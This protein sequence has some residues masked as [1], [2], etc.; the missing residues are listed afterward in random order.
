MKQ[1]IILVNGGTT[2]LHILENILEHLHAHY[3]LSATVVSPKE[4]LEN[5]SKGTILLYLSDEEIK[6]FFKKNISSKLVVGIIPNKLCPRAIRSYGISND[7]FEAIDDI[8][9]NTDTEPVDMLFCNGELTF[10]SVI[11]GDMHGMN[12]TQ[13]NKFFNNIRNFFS[14]LTKLSFIDYSLTT[15]KGQNIQTAATG[16][17]ILE[18][19]IQG[20]SHNLINENLSLRD[21]KLNALI[22]APTSIISYLYYLL[23]TFFYYRFSINKLPKS[24]GL[25]VTSK[26]EITSSKPIEFMLD[27]VG[28]CSKSISLEVVPDAITLRLG[29][30]LKNF[31]QTN[32]VNEDDKDTMRISSLPK[33]EEKLFLI[34]EP[35]PFFKKALEEDFKELFVALKQSAVLSTPFLVLMVL[36]TLLATTGLFQNSAPVIIG[37]MILAPLMSPI[38][39]L[40]MGVVRGEQFLIKE[41]AFTLFIGILTALAFS[42]IYAYLTPL[43]SL[44]SEMNGRLNPNILDLMVAIISGIAGAYANAKSEIAKSL[45]GVA[46]AVALVPPLSVTGI[47]IGFGDLNVI[48]GSFLLFITNLVGITLAASMTFVVLGYAPVHRAKQGIIYTSGFLALVAIPLVFSFMLLIEQ[49]NTMDKLKSLKHVSISGKEVLLHILSV[50]LSK[51]KP[52]VVA[53]VHSAEVLKQNELIE[54]KLRIESVMKEKVTL[55]VTPKI[56]ME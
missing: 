12:Q 24:I 30:H 11:V 54:I 45:A 44:T 3:K 48:S 38:I 47:G 56:I 50:D 43:H 23:V 7:I 20:L 19:S 37:A 36:S 34:S 53:E 10:N 49:N 31:D 15:A 27:G 5:D 55:N 8:F 22:L 51:E 42:C 21:G 6:S 32:S 39:S 28:A 41:S 9:A 14:N 26:L 52:N 25:I 40:S 29:R 33:G 1:D 17:M 2:E 18:H 4:I 13:H 16:I 46:I 35:I